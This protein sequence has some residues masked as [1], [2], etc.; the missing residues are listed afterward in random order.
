MARLM[1]F[2]VARRCR[3]AVSR[4]RRDATVSV[5]NGLPDQLFDR[6]HGFLIERRDDGDRGAGAPG[7][8]G[9]ADAVDVV[10]GMMRHIEI[11]DVAG[12]GNVEAA[13][14]DVGGD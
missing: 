6:D 12:N 14:G 10:V 3:S 7:T 11:E 8:P 9:A 4:R 1:Y 5:G 13:G 2:G